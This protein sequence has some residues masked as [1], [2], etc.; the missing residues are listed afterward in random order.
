MYKYKYNY[1]LYIIFIFIHMLTYLYLYMFLFIIIFQ[2]FTCIYILIFSLM[3][4]KS[5]SFYVVIKNIPHM[6]LISFDGC[7]G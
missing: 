3:S 7:P 6:L 4:D 1:Y 5:K 2:F